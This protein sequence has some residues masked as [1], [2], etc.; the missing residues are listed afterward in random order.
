MIQKL[1]LFPSMEPMLATGHD[2]SSAW[3]CI[4]NADTVF[5][6]SKYAAFSL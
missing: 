1:H 2:A 5:L 3:C 6:P 4:A